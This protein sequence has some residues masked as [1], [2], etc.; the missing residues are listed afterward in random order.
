[1]PQ[2]VPPKAKRLKP[3]K[4]NKMEFQ[5][6]NSTTSRKPGND[7]RR[8]LPKMAMNPASWQTA[9]SGVGFAGLAVTEQRAGTGQKYAHNQHG[10]FKNPDSIQMRQQPNLMGNHSDQKTKTMGHAPA[11]AGA[12]KNPVESGARKWMP[13]ATENFKGDFNRIQNKQMP[14]RRGNDGC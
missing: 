6:K 10:G 5:P 3:L 4:E 12:S 14:N 9:D 8:G 1:M 13:S 7:M 2:S 11:T